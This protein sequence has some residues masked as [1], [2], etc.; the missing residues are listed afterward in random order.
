MLMPDSASWRPEMECCIENKTFDEIAIGDTASLE[1]T[2]TQRDIQFFAVMT[3]DFNPAH[4]DEDY[5]HSDMFH[6]IIAHGMWSGSLISAVLGTLL[7][8]PGTIYLGQ[9][10]RFLGPVSIGDTIVARV[11]VKEKTAEKHHIKLDCVCSNQ[12]GKDVITGEAEVIAPTEKIQRKRIKL[13]EIQF[14]KDTEE[15]K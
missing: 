9:T 10:F 5:A 1:R 11:T 4:V 8:G 7:P 2:L 12:D 14:K 15:A 13:P 3:G 6:K